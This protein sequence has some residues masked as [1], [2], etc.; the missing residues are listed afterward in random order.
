M[1]TNNYHN[2][3]VSFAYLPKPTHTHTHTIIHTIMQLVDLFV[4][5]EIHIVVVQYSVVVYHYVIAILY[6]IKF[7]MLTRKYKFLFHDM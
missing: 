6:P 5:E 4:L 1:Y 2:L 3:S 7:K